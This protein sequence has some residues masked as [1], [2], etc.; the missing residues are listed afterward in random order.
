[1][2]EKAY[3]L[4][5]ESLIVVGNLGV[6][7]KDQG[8]FAKAEPLY[9]RAAEIARNTLGPLHPETIVRVFAATVVHRL[10]LKAEG[11]ALD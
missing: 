10:R 6:V 4:R 7:Y 8:R 2:L 11:K 3:R 9:L 1:M 5:P